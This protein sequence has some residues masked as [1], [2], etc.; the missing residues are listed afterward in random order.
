MMCYLRIEGMWCL[1]NI[2]AMKGSFENFILDEDE[3]RRKLS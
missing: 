2:L 1:F 3:Q